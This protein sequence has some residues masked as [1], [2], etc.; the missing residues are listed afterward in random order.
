M[1]GKPDHIDET[2]NKTIS[3]VLK[4]TFDFSIMALKKKKFLIF[5]YLYSNAQT[6][7]ATMAVLA[8]IIVVYFG[9]PA[10]YG[11]IIAIMVIIFG[12]TSSI[13]YSIKLMKYKNQRYYS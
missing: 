8:N 3:E 9:S 5:V 1:R 2:H 6:S 7:L 10:V 11:S 4:E 13:L 12:L